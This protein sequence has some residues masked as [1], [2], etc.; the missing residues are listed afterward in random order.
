MTMPDL[1]PMNTFAHRFGPGVDLKQA[2]AALLRLRGTRAAVI[3][4]A[5]GSLDGVHLRYADRD[6]PTA[7]AGRWEILSLSG[8]L[9]PDG[10]HVHLA[11]SDG[12]GQCRGGH[13]V[14]GCRVYT[15][16][17]IVFGEFPGLLFARRPDPATGYLELVVEADPS[18]SPTGSARPRPGPAP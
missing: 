17:E 11:V 2:M 12:E 14:D 15:T 9:G 1:Q 4:G 7:L 5:V 6:T 8:T 13:L 10:M 3:L 18:V 16:A